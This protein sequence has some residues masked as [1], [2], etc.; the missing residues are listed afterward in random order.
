ML[1]PSHLSMMV[2]FGGLPQD[3]VMR[4]LQLLGTV[5]LPRL[6]EELSKKPAHALNSAPAA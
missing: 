5:V 2:Q 1:S 4:S 6:R 3:K